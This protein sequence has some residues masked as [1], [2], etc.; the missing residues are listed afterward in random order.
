LE[1]LNL[2]IAQTQDHAQNFVRSGIWG[3]I[4]ESRLQTWIHQ[5]EQY[6][7]ELLGAVLLDNL[8]YKSKAQVISTLSSLMTGPELCSEMGHDLD[9][10]ES[11]RKPKDPGIRLAPAISLSQPPTKSGF[12]V[13]RLLQRLYR[14]KDD[15][16]IWPQTFATIKNT[17]LLIIVD[18]FLGSGTQFS[19]FAGL[20]GIESL[21]D[22]Q[23]NL[24][25]VYL[26][27]AAHATGISF[28]Q[29]K[30]PYVEVICGDILTT[31]H[32]LFASNRID[33]RYRTELAKNLNDQ[34]Q[35][36]LIKASF[37]ENGVT[38]KYGFGNLGLCYAFE[39][40]TPNNTL[41]IYWRQTEHWSNLLD[42]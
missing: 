31:D 13:L 33:T 11:L 21:H 25:I 7:A 38:G 9:L 18:D 32:H 27:V 29:K 20:S 22:A 36:L 15:W 35:E 3:A 19:E 5:F 2:F 40:G 41:P 34:Y 26:V 16:L 1:D 24:R 14:I 12:Y 42:R 4:E 28:I 8:I 6:D 39:H 30:Y 23:P 10:S 37:P 17:K